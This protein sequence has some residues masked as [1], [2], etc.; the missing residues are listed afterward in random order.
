MARD[1]TDIEL[2]KQY[3]RLALALHPD[4]NRAPQS[5]EA[6]K[7][8]FF[9]FFFFSFSVQVLISSMFSCEQGIFHSK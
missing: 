5:D 7:G 6:F 1:A 3:K 2:K 4:K 9:F 8:I